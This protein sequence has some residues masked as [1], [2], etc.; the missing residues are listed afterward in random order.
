MKF[1]FIFLSFSRI[2]LPNSNKIINYWDNQDNLGFYDSKG[3]I[4][5]IHNHTISHLSSINPYIKEYKSISNYSLVDFISKN[6]ISSFIEHKNQN[7]HFFW[8]DTTLYQ[9]VLPNDTF[10]R[11]N[12][13]GEYSILKNKKVKEGCIKHLKENEYLQFS[14]SF[15]N[16]LFII[17]NYNELNIY[18]YQENHFKKRFSHY[19]FYMDIINKVKIQKVNNYIYL[20]ILYR[21]NSLKSITIFHDESKDT[22]RYLHQNN[23]RI[24]DE[25]I[26][27]HIQF[28]YIYILT[29]KDIQCYLI[30]TFENLSQLVFKRNISHYYE[31]IY[32][33]KNK[34]YLSGEKN[35]DFFDIK[36][37]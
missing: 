25:I 31:S 12:Y 24:K 33:F 28:P 36:K 3:N 5:Q 16:F 4:Y 2:F 37:N 23:I 11:M 13:F 15:Q 26:D 18:Q 7:Y 22:F 32:Y 35:I 8:K 17:N 27:L 1:F 34:L 14:S 30:K 10:F 21:D 20:H 9:T 19:L 29:K 6:K